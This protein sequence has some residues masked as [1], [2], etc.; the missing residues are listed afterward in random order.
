MKMRN[1]GHAARIQTYESMVNTHADIL[2]HNF[3]YQV[4]KRAD[5]DYNWNPRQKFGDDIK[6]ESVSAYDIY[7]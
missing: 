2:L 5:M 6:Y 7:S 3:E 1:M 4:R